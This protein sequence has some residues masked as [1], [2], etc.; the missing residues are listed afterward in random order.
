LP[1]AGELA[2]MMFYWL[3]TQDETSAISKYNAFKAAKAAGKISFSN[4]WYWSSTEFN[5]NGAWDVYGG[6][7]VVGTYSKNGSIIVRPVCAF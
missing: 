6:S 1:A 7:G 3:R 5:A 2:R 4:D